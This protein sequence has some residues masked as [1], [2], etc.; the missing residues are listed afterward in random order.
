[1][2]GD[3]FDLISQEQLKQASQ[4][5][6]DKM[7]VTAQFFTGL[8]SSKR[9]EMIQSVGHAIQGM[10]SGKFLE[11]LEKE[12]KYYID[13]GKIK[14]DY[15]KSDQNLMCFIELLRSLEQDLPD[16]SRLELLKKIYI[17]TATEDKS[18]RESPLPLQ[19][20][21]MAKELT[22]GEIL[23]LFAAYNLEGISV[24][25][26]SEFII[27]L[28]TKS[29]LE[30]AEIVTKVHQS[31]F[32]KNYLKSVRTEAILNPILIRDLFTP[33]GRA[34]CDYVVHYDIIEQSAK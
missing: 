4:Y 29:G 25:S 2:D 32:E 28:I 3:G 22:S 12:F 23:V 7:L 9:S 18:S 34:F 8:I 16:P 6:K 27:K 30:Y 10:F 13:A 19:F 26:Q 24:S 15:I 14:D 33:L 11:T 1:M 20:M 21:Q 31:L 17:V 5:Y